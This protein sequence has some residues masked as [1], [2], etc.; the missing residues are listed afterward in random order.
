MSDNSFEENLNSFTH[1]RE[2]L[3]QAI[4]MY[5]AW[6]CQ[7]GL[8]DISGTSSLQG[9]MQGLLTDRITLAFVAEFSRGKTEL[10]N[11]LFF[12]ETGVRLLPS[13]PGRT[14]MCPTELFYDVDGGS[15]IRLL[16]I[17]SRL[18]DLSFDA[19]KE[20]QDRWVNIDLDCESPAQMQAAFKELLAVK[21]VNKDEAIK[22]G[23]FNQEEYE[24]YPSDN[25]DGY[26]IPRWRHALISFPHPLFRNGLT[27]LDTPGLNALG[28]E[29]ELTLS[30]LPSAQAIVFVIAADTGVTKSDMGIWCDHIAK[31]SKQGR[32]VVLNK[33][34][35]LWDDILSDDNAYHIAI[36]DQ[37]ASAAKT[38]GISPDVIF[39]VSARQALIAKIK[40]DTPLLKRSGIA[41]IEAYLSRDIVQQRQGLLMDVVAREIGFFI[42]ESVNLIEIQSAQASGQIQEFKQL[43]L[44]NRELIA[45]LIQDSQNEQSAYFKNLAAFKESRKAFTALQKQLINSMS[46]K[47]IDLLIKQGRLEM[48]KSLSTYGMKQCMR[49]LFDDLRNLLQESVALTL[50]TQNLVRAIY[51]QF[52][53]EHGFQVI[54]PRLFSI[55]QYQTELEQLFEESEAFRLST[56]QV[57]LTEQSLVIKKLY[58]TLLHKA[59]KT[60]D[61]AHEDALKWGRNVMS[62]LVFQIMDYKKQIETRLAVLNSLMKSKNNLQASLDT[63]EEELQ[64]IL[65]QRSELDAIIKNIEGETR[66]FTCGLSK[67]PVDA[68][69]TEVAKSE[70]E[71]CRRKK[72]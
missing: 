35:T 31:T 9:V 41:E 34:D 16:D 24:K 39:P 50:E 13:S 22:L 21:H 48:T 71:N 15:Y 44:E 53:D 2:Q 49:K 1:W 11:A 12:S 45:Q 68:G 25:P 37:L 55:N 40:G 67:R 10:I 58:G 26:E 4:E 32:A 61:N 59:R 54:E 70:A 17:D 56:T 69:D 43:D 36:K 3:V 23:L 29:P 47:K 6:R 8:S 28:S 42:R 57:T 14:T 64:L 65:Y 20:Q 60:L 38:L 62:P 46:R 33:I 72:I 27:I 19:L 5:H 66:V 63:L 18:E 30:M 51:K 7:Y 52:H